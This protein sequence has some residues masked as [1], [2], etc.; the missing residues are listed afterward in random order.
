MRDAGMPI[1]RQLWTVETG[2]EISEATAEVPPSASM[3][4]FAW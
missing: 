1:F 4:L 2:A 3:M